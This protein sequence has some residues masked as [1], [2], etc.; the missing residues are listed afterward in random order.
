MSN[1]DLYRDLKREAERCVDWADLV[2]K[3]YPGGG[4]GVGALVSLRVA[5]GD[6]APTVE[7]HSKAGEPALRPMPG[8]FA[9]Y[10]EAAILAK[11]PE[12]VADALA[13]QRE[14]VRLAA[15]AVAEEYAALAA[16]AGIDVKAP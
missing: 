11:G 13:R 10:L 5:R 6:S 1:I 2:G 3:Q 8:A 12:L 9:P 16:E 4:G 7:F 14:A 15:T